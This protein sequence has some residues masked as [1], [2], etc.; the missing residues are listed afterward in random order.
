MLPA[1]VETKTP[2]ETN[3]LLV[4]VN[5]NKED[6]E[7]ELNKRNIP[8]TFFI[9]R[10]SDYSSTISA[11]EQGHEIANHTESHFHLREIKSWSLRR[12]ISDFKMML[13][14]NT[15][16][17][18]KTFAYPFGEGGES[19]SSDYEIQDTVANGHIAAR[20][21]SQPLN[22]SDYSYNF[23]PNERDYFQIKHLL[24]NIKKF[25]IL[26]HTQH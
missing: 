22:D 26:N 19:D 6:V 21:V 8:G 16:S 3:F 20:S 14:E 12:Q 2:S 7:E 10:L 11:I 18:I 13:E 5:K 1:G 15:G 25:H 4:K 17:L 23:A 9:N 24:G